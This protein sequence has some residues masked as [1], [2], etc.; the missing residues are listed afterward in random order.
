MRVLL[1]DDDPD[2]VELLRYALGRQ[3]Y[4]VLTATDGQQGLTRWRAQ[5]PDLVLLDG[6]LPKLD[7]FEVC[8]QIRQEAT[9]PVI[10]LTARTE[11]AAV[12]RGLQLGADD[13]V[14]KPFSARQLAARIEA[15]LRR[16]G[17]TAVQRPTRALQVGNLALDLDSHHVIRAGRS[18]TLSKIE[19]RLVQVLA[20]NA[21]RVVPYA[22][23]IEHAWGYANESSA[24]S[25]AAL[26]KVHMSHLRR[27]LGLAAGEPGGIRAIIGVG[28]LLARATVPRAPDPDPQGA[29]P[30]ERRV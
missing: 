5:R 1:V 25:S 10:L 4:E 13:Y 28:Y 8:R 30:E 6:T 11:E 26:L 20:M 21:G 24:E 9:T 12:V 14:T 17:R 22:R 19:F 27:K 3:G 15:V 29:T 23:L 2:H 16:T 18:V 7:G